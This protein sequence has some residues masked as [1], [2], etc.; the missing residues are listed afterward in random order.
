MNPDNKLNPNIFKQASPIQPNLIN[1]LSFQRE[2]VS[3]QLKFLQKYP[4]NFFNSNDAQFL[5]TQ[6]VKSLENLLSETEIMNKV[7]QKSLGAMKI[8][9]QVLS[10]RFKESQE[11][12]KQFKEWIEVLKEQ[13]FELSLSLVKLLTLYQ[14][15]SVC[16]IA[17]RLISL[18]KNRKIRFFLFFENF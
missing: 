6:K 13:N 7:T 8:K 2:E 15:Y 4:V 17:E 18:V 1:D 12:N 5:L 9:N 14:Q 10:E 16:T 11:Q 3:S